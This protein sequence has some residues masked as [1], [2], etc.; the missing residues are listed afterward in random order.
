[1]LASFHVG[2][3]EVSPIQAKEKLYPTQKPLA[4]LER[5]VKASSNRGNIVLDPFCGCG[6]PIVSA[7]KL[8]RNWIGID[9]SLYVA[10]LI[11]THRFEGM[12]LNTVDIPT[13]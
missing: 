10:D 8:N 5:I 12:K 13:D 2:Y 11:E 1:M 9:I 6:T 4:L 7:H 3:S